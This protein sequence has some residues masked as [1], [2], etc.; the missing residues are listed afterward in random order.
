M[1]NGLEANILQST[2]LA[3]NYCIGCG[4]C[5]TV[6]GSPFRIKMDDFGNYVAFIDKT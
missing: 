5:A 2:V 6:P 1:D 3:G 4:V